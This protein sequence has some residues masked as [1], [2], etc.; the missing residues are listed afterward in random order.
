MNYI[1]AYYHT[2]LLLLLN[3][4]LVNIGKQPSIEKPIGPYPTMV[5]QPSG[6]QV[7]VVQAYAF[8]KYLGYLQTTFNDDGEMTSH[9]GNP[10]L[11]DGRIKQ[12]RI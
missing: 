6:R 1:L 11:L 12:G 8:G 10:I 7:P 5:K 2:M 4:T 3:H 9:S